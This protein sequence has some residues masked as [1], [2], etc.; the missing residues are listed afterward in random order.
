MGSSTNGGVQGNSSPLVWEE[1]EDSRAT[2]P[3][4]LSGLQ[5]FSTYGDRVIPLPA[6]EPLLQEEGLGPLGWIIG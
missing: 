2:R 6:S 1:Q 5:F 4:S 3:C